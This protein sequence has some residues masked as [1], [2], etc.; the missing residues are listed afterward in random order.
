[1]RLRPFAHVL[2][3]LPRSAISGHAVRDHHR[4]Y[5][6]ISVARVLQIGKRGAIPAS[7]LAVASVSGQRHTRA[8]RF[9]NR[10]SPFFRRFA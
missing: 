10:I 1:M 3:V 8:P 9:Q 5:A 7:R 4:R 6:P 2:H